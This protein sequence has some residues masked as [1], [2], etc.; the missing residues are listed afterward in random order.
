[1]H[2]QREKFF[3]ALRKVFH[4][5]SWR[6]RHFIHTSFLNCI[7][8]YTQIT[9]IF[10]LPRKLYRHMHFTFTIEH[11]QEMKRKDNHLSQ[12][13][14]CHR[15]LRVANNTLSPWLSVHLFIALALQDCM[16]DFRTHSQHKLKILRAVSVETKH[17]TEENM[18]LSFPFVPKITEIS[19]LL[20]KDC[21]A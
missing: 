9:L 1:M 2:P 10:Y 18:A 16:H 13:S 17:I 14:G 11:N 21:S 7:Y 19:G 15:S 3:K 4:F 6:I 5:C 12:K 20:A 8:S